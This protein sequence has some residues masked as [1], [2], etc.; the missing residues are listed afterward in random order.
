MK[1][2]RLIKLITLITL[3]KIFFSPTPIFAE[4]KFQSTFDLTYKVHDQGL[5]TVT[6]NIHL[7]NLT[8]E[9]FPSEYVLKLGNLVPTNLRAY[10]RTGPLTLIATSS[11]SA[12]EIHIKFRDQ[13][14]G[15]NNTLHWTLTYDT[16]DI[17]KHIGRLW[18]ITI[19][20][21]QQPAE[22]SSSTIGLYVPSSFGPAILK[23]PEPV[24]PPFIWDES[25]ARRG[26]SASFLDSPSKT[27]PY[28]TYR[29]ELTYH[30]SNPS[31]TKTDR[32]VALP[33][34][35]AY[36]KIA[37]PSLS[38][39]PTNISH[40]PDGNW[41]GHFSLNP[42]SKIDLTIQGLAAV[43]S[44]PQ[45]K[46][47]LVKSADYLKPDQFWEVADPEI[48]SLA[49][50]LRSPQAIYDYVV[51]LLHYDEKRLETR[52]S[53]AGAKI[54]LSRPDSAI[55]LEFTD[56]FIALSRAA[57]IPAREINGFA[58]TTSAT[59]EPLSLEKDVLHSWPEYFD[60]PSQTW[61][62][63]DPTWGSTTAGF[64]YFRSLDLG[65]LTFAI[66][67]Q[68]STKPKPAGTYKK[69]L[70]TQMPPSQVT[71]DVSVIPIDT[72]FPFFSP[73]PQISLRTKT[74]SP[75]LENHLT[76]T[77]TNPN[78]TL[79]SPQNFTVTSPGISFLKTRF[80]SPPIP[81]FG[82]INLALPFRPPSWTQ[83][84]NAIISFE[85]GQSRQNAALTI[86]PLYKHPFVVFG[87]LIVISILSVFAKIS[88]RL[89]L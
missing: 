7:T 84:A 82:Q 74:I 22:S 86:T 78:P 36:Q 42:L 26:I 69:L 77:I 46:E 61:I 18:Q 83:N 4:G 52:Q 49:K 14:V 2:M 68:S 72:P 34:D 10:D 40:D 31:L 27:E 19:P 29:F 80:S 60:Q 81:P 1:A 38:P 23:K 62:M 47:P 50:K 5:T 28:Q 20:P 8:S 73:S 70:S 39:K 11:G 45:N 12:S 88:R 13:V 43:Y 76:I 33:P 59:R 41:L 71:K 16:L 58:Y 48:S 32:Q 67:G 56:L 51:K 21:V 24:F 89:L 3:I 54:A 53:R 79:L 75:F 63:V 64:D 85:S 87:G 44:R 30:L 55:C 37:F 65:H 25:T 66:H 6:Q 35:T 15:I 57:G 17:A 9:F